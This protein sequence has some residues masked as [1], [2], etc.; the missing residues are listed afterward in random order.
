MLHVRGCV[1]F[2]VHLGGDGCYWNANK[3]QQGV[4]SGNAM[5]TFAFLGI[6]KKGPQNFFSTMRTFFRCP[7]QLLEG[8]GSVA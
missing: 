7:L 3:C 5:R 4:G 1:H 2:A 8:G 6:L